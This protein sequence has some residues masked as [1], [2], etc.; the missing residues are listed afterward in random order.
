MFFAFNSSFSKLLDIWQSSNTYGH[1][2]L[3]LPI[4]L[5]LIHRKKH[6]LT[7]VDAQPS[8]FAL[9]LVGLASFFWFISVLS[10]I[11]VI[12]QF[13]L[14]TLFVV[15]TWA[16]FGLKIVLSLKFPL[17]FLFLSIPV[18]DFLVPYLQFITA[19]ISVFMIQ[20]L[21]IP[22]FRDGM[23]IQIPNG[24]FLVAEAC[25]GIRFLIST[26]TI[27]VLYSYLNFSKLYKQVI[28]VLLCCVVA[29]I[30]N[31]L[32]AFLMILIGH[33]SNMQ[34]AVGFDHFVYGGVFFVIILSIL[35]V[36][37]HYMSDPITETEQPITKNIGS[38]QK[39]PSLVFIILTFT[40]LFIGPALK[41]KYEN[42]I[43]LLTSQQNIN[44]IESTKIVE[45]T[46]TKFNHNWLP[47]FPDSDAIYTSAS[48]STLTSN[49]I[50]IFIAK[51][52]YETD[53]KEII[54]Y[55]NRLFDTD[56]WSIKGISA[57]E[58]STTNGAVI[59]Y[60]SFTIVN[61]QG[62]ERKLRVIY[63]V[64]DTFSANKIQFKLLQLINKIMMTDFGGEV[65]VL[66]SA[67]KFEADKDLDAFMSQN[68]FEIK[69][70]VTLVK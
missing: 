29:I 47:G 43:N 18:G 42:Y 5:W 46:I 25:S 55:R 70:Q 13:A 12:E 58:I 14:F 20:I 41:Y 8:F 52:H 57:N 64:N 60:S 26:V 38:L 50:D 48:L 7:Q 66:S 33:L 39:C 11:N 59:P 30:G 68:F 10:Y 28:F 3:I 51:Y 35:F 69:Q 21:G 63:K 56:F 49:N 1:G 61:M 6:V 4:V 40:L 17:A 37:G 45:N 27:G 32:R 54:S 24:N 34:A 65:I 36:I 53:S 44:S 19:D 67:N 2:V 31:G 15:L 16:F 23:Y 22:V 62:V 9:F